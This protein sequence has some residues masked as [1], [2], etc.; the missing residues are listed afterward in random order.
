MKKEIKRFAVA[1]LAGIMLLASATT[2]FADQWQQDEKGWWYQQSN[3]LYPR[4]SWK[5]ITGADGVTKCYYFN[6]EGYCLLNTTT[7][8]GY[9]VNADGA[10]TVNGV[11]QT[12]QAQQSQNNQSDSQQTGFDLSWVRNAE[13]GVNWDKIMEDCEEMYYL[14]QAADRMYDITEAEL[15]NMYAQM[16]NLWAQESS[17]GAQWKQL[18]ERYGIPTYL[19]S[20]M[21]KTSTY[22]NHM[23]YTL[24]LPA[25][26]TAAEIDGIAAAF[27]VIE[28]VGERY[29][30]VCEAGWDYSWSTSAD[31]I[32]TV[33][34]TGDMNDDLGAW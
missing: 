26:I 22:I 31:G 17:K 6:S 2:A 3:G 20:Y 29:Y 16:L 7:P 23:D 10:W 9:T 19:G 11:V 33:H 4:G 28:T 30:G 32:L 1:G 21:T 8:D 5:W 25:G 13:G 27:A 18:I 24:T 12:K 34:F 14:G 15:P